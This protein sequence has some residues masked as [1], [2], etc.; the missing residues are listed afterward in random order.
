MSHTVLV[1]GGLRDLQRK[2]SHR[3][4]VALMRFWKAFNELENYSPKQSRLENKDMYVF[5]IKIL[6]LMKIKLSKKYFY[7]LDIE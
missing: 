6:I 1:F 7:L 5:F 2:I 3:I 4:V